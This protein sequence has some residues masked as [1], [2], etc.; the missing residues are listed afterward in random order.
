MAISK[1]K[2]RTDDSVKW[3]L[4]SFLR[5]IFFQNNECI[6]QIVT[7]VLSFIRQFLVNHFTMKETTIEICAVI[8]YSGHARRIKYEPCKVEHGYEFHITFPQS[9]LNVKIAPREV[10]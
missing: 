2:I 1:V 4:L 3:N 5:F 9:Y 8:S 7:V 6:I 10:Q